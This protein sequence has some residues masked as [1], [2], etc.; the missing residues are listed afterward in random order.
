MSDE[1]KKKI[2]KVVPLSSSFFV[3]SIVGLYVSLIFVMPRSADFG[4]AFA[5]VFAVMFI[6]SM[7]SLTYAPAKALISLEEYEKKH[8]EAKVLSHSEYVKKQKKRR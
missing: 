4:V 6:S 7:V 5:I 3:T 2:P 1:R 8:K